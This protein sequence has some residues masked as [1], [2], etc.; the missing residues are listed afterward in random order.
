MSA[1]EITNDTGVPGFDAPT[2]R[3][4]NAA[5]LH[6]IAATAAT[7]TPFTSIPT[8]DISPL[9]AGDDESAMQGVAEAIRDACVEVGFFY[10]SGHGVARS[11]VDETFETTKRFFHPSYEEK[12]AVSILN[13]P[14]MRGYTG[15][16]EENTDPDGGGD[17]HE[18][19]DMGLDL[20]DSDPDAHRDVYGWGL[21][22]WPD[23]PG[24]RDRMVAY[25]ETMSTLAA[26]LYRGFALS[27]GLDANFF[28]PKM[29][30]PISE[31]RIIRYPAQ[32]AA[33]DIDGEVVGIGAHSDYDMFTILGTDDVPALEVLNSAGDWIPV[34]PVPDTFVVNV[35][36]LLERMTNDLYRST[37]HRVINST[38]Q[39]RFS[40]PFFSN[41][42]P[43]E[44]V[45][46]LES[47]VTEDR[48]ARYEPVAAGAYVEAC[49]HESYGYGG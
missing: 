45:E 4:R 36:D 2:L 17:L 23:M 3:A 26:A 38:E 15:L 28:V 33:T 11:F 37:V 20:A 12:A 22:Q 49:M 47:C 43:L 16:L 27:L 31:L 35:G 14:K 39:E 7:A 10:V 13:S 18:A 41:I 9:I 19:F 34:P 48:P 32:P 30:K 8:V 44:V 29:T 1:L 25:H 40:L 42:D 6:D 24:F 46:V 5:R 21:N